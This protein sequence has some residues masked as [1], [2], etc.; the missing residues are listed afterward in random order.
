MNQQQKPTSN[1]IG[2]MADNYK[3]NRFKKE[4][5]KAGFTFTTEQTGP[6]TLIKVDGDPSKQPKINAI[7]IKVEAYFNRSN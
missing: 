4:L 2:I 1:K 5:K 7:C 3:V 6:I